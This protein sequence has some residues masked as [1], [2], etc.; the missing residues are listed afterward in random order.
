MLKISR[1]CATVNYFL[2]VKPGDNYSGNT[3][4]AGF[5][6]LSIKWCKA[7]ASQKQGGKKQAKA[8]IL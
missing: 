3:Y 6:Y 4:L 2:D 1:R 7:R 5:V 8:T